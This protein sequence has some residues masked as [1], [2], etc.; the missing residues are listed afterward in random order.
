MIV[1]GRGRSAAQVTFTTDAA[2]D[3]V[4]MPASVATGALLALPLTSP[5]ELPRALNRGARERSAAPRRPDNRRPVDTSDNAWHWSEYFDFSGFPPPQADPRDTPLFKRRWLD[6]VNEARGRPCPPK[7]IGADKAA[8]L[9]ALI[10]PAWNAWMSAWHSARQVSGG[11]VGVAA[12]QAAIITLKSAVLIRGINGAFDSFSASEKL[13]ADVVGAIADVTGALTQMSADPAA[14]S[15]TRPIDQ[16]ITA[17][18]GLIS[19][20]EAQLLEDNPAESGVAGG[21]GNGL[22]ALGLLKAAFYDLAVVLNEQVTDDAAKSANQYE[23]AEDVYHD[24]ID[25]YEKALAEIRLEPVDCDNPPPPP[26]TDTLKQPKPEGQTWRTPTTSSAAPA[27]GPA[28]TCVR[29]RRWT[30]P[31]TSRTSRPPACR[32]A[33]SPSRTRSMPT[34]TWRASLSATSASRTTSSRCPRGGGR[35]AHGSTI[36]PR[37]ASTSTWSPGSTRRRGP[38]LDVDVGRSRD[39]RRSR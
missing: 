33:S 34:S 12:S 32:R 14:S 5:E 8:A 37:A 36:A 31:S 19:V 10:D 9:S 17:V 20:A 18:G 3:P 28:T 30:T 27:T 25:R 6:I 7:V 38:S 24:T 26:P 13:A 11:N 23:Q 16:M 1:K 35:T 4:G 15:A 21:L 39:G 2:G 29:E 22:A